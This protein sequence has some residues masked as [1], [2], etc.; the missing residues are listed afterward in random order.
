MKK[1]ILFTGLLLASFAAFGQEVTDSTSSVTYTFGD[2]LMEFL[3]EN[4]KALAAVILFFVSEWFGET[5]QFPEGSIWRKVINWILEFAKKQVTKSPK[6]KKI[7]RI[8]EKEIK[9]NNRSVDFSKSFKMLTVGL[10]LSGLTLTS[11][12]QDNKHPHRWYP[13]KKKTEL[14]STDGLQADFPLFT[15]D[16]TLWF[17]PSASFDVF[18]KEM[19]TGEYTIGAIPGIGYGLKWNPFR[20]ENHYLI[21]L[22]VY[23]QAALMDRAKVLD[24]E[25][26]ET[27]IDA[28]YFSVKLLPAI[29]LLNWV[30]VGYGPL[31]NIGL[32]DTKGYITGVFLIGVTKEF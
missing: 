1:K 2:S 4:W 10:I 9:A 22:D 12:A 27:D 17:G 23:A 13:F 11:L 26:V 16:S 25:G 28:R 29:S 6:L 21:G 24:G 31:F 3:N 32:K 8:Y 20:W 15:R 30:H 7:S 5:D 19:K 14:V 18:T